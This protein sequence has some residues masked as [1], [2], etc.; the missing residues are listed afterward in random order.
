MS[1]ELLSILN[2]SLGAGQ[3]ASLSL[4]AGVQR[5]PPF[6]PHPTFAKQASCNQDLVGPDLTWCRLAIV[7]LLG[8]ITTYYPCTFIVIGLVGS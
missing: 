1:Q 8:L 2:L 4:G 5:D 6:L 7:L 3:S